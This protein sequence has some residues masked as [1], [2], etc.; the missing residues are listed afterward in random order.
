[1]PRS[2]SDIHIKYIGDMG[3][4]LSKFVN[5]VLVQSELRQIKERVRGLFHR[6]EAAGLVEVHHTWVRDLMSMKCRADSKVHKLTLLNIEKWFVLRL[7]QEERQQVQ[8]QQGGAANRV[9]MTRENFREIRSIIAKY[10]E[11][12]KG[13]DWAM[14]P[15]Q[16]NVNLDLFVLYNKGFMA[17]SHMASDSRAWHLMKARTYFLDDA[18]IPYA[19]NTAYIE[20][21]PNDPSLPVRA[22]IRHLIRVMGRRWFENLIRSDHDS[23][24]GE[25]FDALNNDDPTTAK[26]VN[27]ANSSLDKVGIVDVKSI[28]PSIHNSA[29]HS[30]FSETLVDDAMFGNTKWFTESAFFDSYVDLA[31]TSLKD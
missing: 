13:D 26:E 3:Q 28:Q 31:A 23:F 6:L 7:D 9:G 1:M 30:S 24:Y 19:Y 4:A 15:N 22:H 17:Y 20:R 10:G 2:V 8:A 21:H 29:V 27:E 14:P 12:E 16:L 5:R 11:Q 25:F 18:V